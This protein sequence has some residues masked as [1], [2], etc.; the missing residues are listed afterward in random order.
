MTFTDKLF[1]AM[2]LMFIFGAYCLI[3]HFAFEKIYPFNLLPDRVTEF[4]TFLVWSMPFYYF[5][6]RYQI[7]LY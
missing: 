6:H 7:Q 2:T 5:V 4:L 1:T 3:T